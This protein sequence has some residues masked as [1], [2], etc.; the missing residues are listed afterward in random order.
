MRLDKQKLKASASKLGGSAK[1]AIDKLARRG[2]ET[3]ETN[4][5]GLKKTYSEWRT[6]A[7]EFTRAT[8]TKTKDQAQGVFDRVFY[9][10][11][12]MNKLQRLVRYQGGYYREL[13]KSRKT[14]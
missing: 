6:A 12:R 9:S 3:W 7:E 1:T 8:G 10:K 5:P 4:S 11:E 2:Q 14:T 13:C